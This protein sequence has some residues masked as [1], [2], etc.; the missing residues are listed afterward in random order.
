M[1][2]KTAGTITSTS[3]PPCDSH[4]PLTTLSWT[5]EPW[6]ARKNTGSQEAPSL[7]LD[8]LLGQSVWDCDHLTQFSQLY[9]FLFFFLSFFLFFSILVL[10]LRTFTLSHSTGPI[11]VKDFLR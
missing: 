6:R 11:S 9:S 10:E 8:L 7:S 4:S 1:S 2:P 5:Q 3:P